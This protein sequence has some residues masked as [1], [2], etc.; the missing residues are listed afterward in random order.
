MRA[1][2]P[3]LVVGS[4]LLAPGVAAGDTDTYQVDESWKL[5]HVDGDPRT[6]P[7]AED[8]VV[9]LTCHNEDQMTDWWVNDED[10]VARSWRK[11]D[12][13]GVQVEPEFPDET[14]TLEITIMCE[15]M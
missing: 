5:T 11:A 13:T 15:K 6:V 4:M 14:R 2:V 9:E 12:G 10:L 3:V 7:R 8:D 1:I